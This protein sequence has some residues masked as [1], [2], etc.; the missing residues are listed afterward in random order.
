MNMNAKRLTTLALANCLLGF[1]PAAAQDK[2]SPWSFSLDAMFASQ[3]LWRGYVPNSSPALQP[4]IS[5]GYEGFS[6]SSWSNVSHQIQGYGQNW[7][8]HD[9]TLNYSHTFDKLSIGGGYIWYLY[10]GI[11]GQP[12]RDS[13]EFYLGTSYDTLLKPSFTFYRD[14]DE[15]D[16][17]YF[18]A[19][20]GHSV[21]LGKGV[22]LNLGSGIGLNNRQ[23]IDFTTGSNWHINVSVDIPWG[24]VTFSPFFTQMIG[25]E[26]VFGKHNMFGVNMSVIDF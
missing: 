8:E 20:I 10:P 5:L 2:G 6:V 13:H 18:Y 11:Q 26:S 1:F 15:G 16:G 14:F 9:L 19:S 3:Y 17:N 25:N 22:A 21:D 7:M 4:N 12:G 23:W 24:K